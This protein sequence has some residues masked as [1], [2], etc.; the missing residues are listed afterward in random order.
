MRETEMETVDVVIVG[1][2]P[3]GLQA[4]LVL[5]RTRKEIVVF[6]APAPP[7]NGASHGVHNFLGLDGMLPQEIRDR[8]W[9]Q[10]DMY[11]FAE[12]RHEWVTD[13]ELDGAANFLVT[14]GS[15]KQLRA[16]CVILALGYRDIHPALDGFRDAWARTIIPCPF[17]DGYENRDRIWAVVA[18]H[19]MEAL[20]FPKVAQNWT[21]QIKLI[22]QN[23]AISLEPEYERSLTRLGIPVHRGTIVAIDQ[24]GGRV[25]GIKLDSG[26][27]IAAQTL[28]WSPDEAPTE[29]VQKLVAR[30]D[31]AL[32]EMG[33]L[34]TD[35]YFAT[36]VPGLYA[37]GDVQGWAGAI[38]AATAGSTAAAMIVRGW[39]A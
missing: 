26:E 37:V 36:K 20:H 21:R 12:L 10:I 4:A 23:K 15:G 25:S 14:E 3:A 17:C 31:L 8:A 35:N 1:G 32:N 34:K 6:D 24:E 30:F 7:R 22:L 39:Y 28:L 16:R 5:A 2:G 18:N 29:L 11:G 38:E 9:Q 19:E 33:H 27:Y 13:V